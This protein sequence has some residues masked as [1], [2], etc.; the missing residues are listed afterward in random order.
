MRCPRGQRSSSLKE[1]AIKVKPVRC[2]LAAYMVF[3]F[4]ERSSF[5]RK[6]DRETPQKVY[7]TAY[8]VYLLTLKV[9]FLTQKVYL[10]T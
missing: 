3:G 9:L 10:L 4:A 2:K 1:P 8:K 5:L 7:L 6:P